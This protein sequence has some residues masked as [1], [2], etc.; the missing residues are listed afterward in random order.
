MSF[1]P[2]GRAF[3]D[4]SSPRAF[5][6]CDR[7]G[8]WY[9]HRDL[10]WQ[11]E[12]AGLQLINIGSLVCE[13]CLDIPQIQ[14]KII[15]LPA[16]PPPILN[17]RVEP[18]LIDEAGPTQELVCEIV[19]SQASIPASFYLDL[20]DADP[21][22]GGTSVLSTLTG[23]ATRTNYASSMSTV[24]TKATNN[25]AITI[26]TSADA[27]ASVGWVAIFSAATAGTLVM[28]GELQ[29][30]QT[31]TILNGAEFEVGALTVLLS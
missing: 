13:P 21:S 4:S 30:P 16:D 5:A 19:T 2:T 27:T 7:C 3:V 1:N 14:L 6:V 29:P 15:I 10:Q 20:Y 31:V 9:N 22:D 8:R 24:G 17:A 25:A 28:S 12:W 26:T 18:F 23:S 11:Y